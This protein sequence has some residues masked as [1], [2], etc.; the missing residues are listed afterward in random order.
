MEIPKSMVEMAARVVCNKQIGADV[1]DD[2]EHSIKLEWEKVATAALKAAFAG[3]E[4]VYENT[5]AMTHRMDGNMGTC[6]VRAGDTLL[7]LR[8]GGEASCSDS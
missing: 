7:I 6:E 8:A 5:T 3:V 1:F 2:L 4:V